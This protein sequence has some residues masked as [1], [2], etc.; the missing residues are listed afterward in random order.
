MWKNINDYRSDSAHYSVMSLIDRKK[1][2]QAL[3]KM[4]TDAEADYLNFVLFSTSGVH[5]TC[6]LI[7]E[8]EK[9]INGEFDENGEEHTNH[10]TFLVVHPRLVSLRYGECVP[11]TNEDIEFLKKLRDSSYKAVK[12]IGSE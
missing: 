6:N 9:A 12:N 5:G 7:E 1:G 3:K 11:E 10:V 4:F 2:M 8:A